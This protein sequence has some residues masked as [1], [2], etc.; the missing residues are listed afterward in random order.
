[1]DELLHPFLTDDPRLA[2]TL[3][4]D[5]DAIHFMDSF[6]PGTDPKI[7]QDYLDKFLAHLRTDHRRWS[8]HVAERGVD[9]SWTLQTGR[10]RVSTC[11]RHFET[12]PTSTPLRYTSWDHYLETTTP[13]ERRAMCASRT[14]KANSRRLMSRAREQRVTADDIWTVVAAAMGRCA[15]CDSLCL[16][17]LPNDP[18]TKKKRPWGHIGRRIGSLDHLVSRVSGGTN[19]PE[20]LAWSCLWCNSAFG[21]PFSFQISSAPELWPWREKARPFQV[22]GRLRLPSAPPFSYNAPVTG[23]SSAVT[24]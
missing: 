9:A 15:H 14:Q 1:M 7:Y 24:F 18:A 20:N 2:G 6:A 4:P 22:R 8:A 5:G 11:L 19:D 16:E 21:A 23:S 13:S 10:P 12:T 17:R 3:Y